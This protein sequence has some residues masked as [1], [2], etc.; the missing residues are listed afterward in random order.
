[1][2]E[3]TSTVDPAGRR[4]VL[5]AERWRHITTEHPQVTALRAEI[6]RT[7]ARP[8]FVTPDPIASRTCYWRRAVGPSIWLR[9]IVDFDK[10]PARIVTAFPNRRNPPEWPSVLTP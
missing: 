1:V 6:V 5:T 2:P 4:V 7:V 9:V 3:P 8:D 10:E